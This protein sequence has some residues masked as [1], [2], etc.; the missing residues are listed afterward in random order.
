[1]NLA[2]LELTMQTTWSTAN[3]NLPASASRMMELM[4]P[5]FGVL[6]LCIVLCIF[7]QKAFQSQK[8]SLGIGL[9]VPS[10][11]CSWQGSLIALELYQAE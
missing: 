1:M 4:T 2:I 8:I 11:F 9:Q 3:R 10:S 6:F 7:M 5:S